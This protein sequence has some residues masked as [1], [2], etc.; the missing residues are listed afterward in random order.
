MLHEHILTGHT[1][2]GGTVLHI[3]G[4]VGGADDDQF[5]IVMVG[6][7]NQLAAFFRIIFWNNIRLLE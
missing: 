6:V 5:D 3:G 1:Q 2:V 4:H 7:Q